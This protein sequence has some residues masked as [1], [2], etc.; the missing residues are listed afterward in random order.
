MAVFRQHATEDVAPGIPV[1]DFRG[2]ARRVRVTT[3]V[4]RAM[5]IILAI[6]LV[7]LAW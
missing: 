3:G 5:L 4:E 7:P 1:L 6:V 2:A